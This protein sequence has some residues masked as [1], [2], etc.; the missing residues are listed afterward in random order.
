MLYICP[1]PIGNLGD[2]TARVLDVLRQ[3]DIIAA[4]DTRR[5]RRLL[6]HFGIDKPLTSFFEH[7]EVRRLPEILGRLKKGDAIALVS[8]AGMPGICDPGYTLVRAA[9]DENL[10]VEVLPGPSAI[11]TALVASG[12]P[13][14]AFLFVGYMPRKKNERRRALAEIASQGRTCVAFESPRRLSRT[15]AEADTISELGRIA[16]CRELTK[17][18]QEVRRGRASE[19]I[20]QMPDPVK[21]E[22]VLVFEPTKP[23]A[24]EGAGIAQLE[25]AIRELLAEGL[26]TK[27]V[28]ELLSQLT[29]TPKSRV[30]ELA[31]QLKKGIRK[32]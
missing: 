6:K 1:T 28:A 25:H 29:G 26:S 30:Y 20:R 19:L 27:R 7:N 31:I 11:E 9:L 16:V 14:D 2:I 32:V 17:R 10:P 18:Y 5:T 15:L 24:T 21:G 22:V 23:D 3:V 4:E 8:D 13:T 12:F